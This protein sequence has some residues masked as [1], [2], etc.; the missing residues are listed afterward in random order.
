MS[1]NSLEKGSDPRPKGLFLFF[2]VYD[3]QIL[4]YFKTPL[5]FLFLLFPVSPA[6]CSALFFAK[7]HPDLSGAEVM[8]PSFYHPLPEMGSLFFQFLYFTG[9][10][11]NRSQK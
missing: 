11:V 1:L 9:I 10:F 2:A 4:L 6:S 3:A 5:H 8:L 7:A